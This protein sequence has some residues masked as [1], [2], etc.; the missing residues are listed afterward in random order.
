MIDVNKTGHNFKKHEEESPVHKVEGA[1]TQEKLM[2]LTS[3]R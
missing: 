3:D 1:A 2:K